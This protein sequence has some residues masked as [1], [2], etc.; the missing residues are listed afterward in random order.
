MEICGGAG[1]VT[2]I[3]IRRR[4]KTGHNF[5]LVTGGDLT[6]KENVLQLMKYVRTYK[7]LVVVMAPPCTAMGGWAHLNKVI[8]PETYKATRH[9]GDWRRCP[10]CRPPNTTQL[11]E[12]YAQNTEDQMWE[13][14][15]LRKR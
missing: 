10:E 1:G 2:K 9:I 4:L 13:L 15:C 8:H 12:R 3:G 7:P 6:K 14:A 5:D 11:S